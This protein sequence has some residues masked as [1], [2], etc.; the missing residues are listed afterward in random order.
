[1][2]CFKSWC[3]DLKNC[4]QHSKKA[5]VKADDISDLEKQGKFD[6][7]SYRANPKETWHPS[8]KL[9]EDFESRRST[10]EDILNQLRYPNVNIVG[11]H[12]MGGVGKTTLAREVGNQAEE[13]ML[14]DVVVFV[15]ISEK[16]EI[17]K[18]QEAIA[19]KLGLEF[20]ERSESGRAR[21]LCERLKKEIKLL[22]I[23][24]N[25]W[26]GLDL[27][28]V[29]IPFGND[30]P[31]CKLLLT[32]RNIDVLSNDMNSLQNFSIG[33]LNEKEA[34][35]LFKK[36]AGACTEQHNLQSL[37]FDVAKRCGGLPIAIVTIAK[38]LKDKQ[39]HTWRNVLGEL[40]RPSSENLV[41][42]V[43]A[44]A[45]SCIRLSIII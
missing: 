9:Y 19:D 36:V 26:K 20:H 37:A 1:M 3:P 13:Q 5:A 18:I 12:G 7:I 4:Y 29:G 14:F 6:R 10:V 23:L 38:A 2:R 24:D 30:H 31:G 33:D 21:K 39:V 8:S 34:W 28:R 22:L 35:D 25:I 17:R 41:G 44:E 16:P 11:V 32:T 27:E 42:S 40:I 45:Y 15:E 43:T